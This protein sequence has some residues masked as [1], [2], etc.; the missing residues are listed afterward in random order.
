MT[1]I[2]IDYVSTINDNGSNLNDC[3]HD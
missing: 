1:V 2:M 3:N